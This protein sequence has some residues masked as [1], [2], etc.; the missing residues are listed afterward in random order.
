MIDAISSWTALG[1]RND[2]VDLWI[3]EHWA[4]KL[5]YNQCLFQRWHRLY[6]WWGISLSAGLVHHIDPEDYCRLSCASS[7]G[8]STLRQTVYRDRY[9]WAM[10]LGRISEGPRWER[11][12]QQKQPIMKWVTKCTSK[13]RWSHDFQGGLCSIQDFASAWED[14]MSRRKPLD[15][16]NCATAFC[17]LRSLA[18]RFFEMMA[19]SI[20]IMES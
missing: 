7:S 2:S 20:R 1:L 10:V 12:N 5:T 15:L 11:R 9:E 4:D 14:Q 18:I 8:S 13:A 16:L 3:V 17:K 6:S 19:G